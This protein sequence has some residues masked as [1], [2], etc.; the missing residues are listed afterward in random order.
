MACRGQHVISL[1]H[2]YL[3]FYLCI[4]STSVYILWHIFRFRGGLDVSHGQTGSQSVYTVFRGQ[5]LMFHISTKLPY[6]EGDTQQV[7][8]MIMIE[9]QGQL[10]CCPRDHYTFL[11][12]THRSKE[13]GILGMTLW[14][15]FFKRRPRRL[16]LTWSLPISSMPTFWFKWKTLE[17]MTPHTRFVIKISW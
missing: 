14:L 4:L 16:C 3:C 7:L 9:I 17:Q 1:H 8:I 12:P 10:V 13:S 2:K 15:Q 11:F 5:E 6:T